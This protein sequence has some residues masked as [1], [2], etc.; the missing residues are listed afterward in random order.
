M[1]TRKDD[2][3]L[4]QWADIDSDDAAPDMSEELPASRESRRHAALD[5]EGLTEG[6]DGLWRKSVDNA[7]WIPQ[8]E[9]GYIT[10][11]VVRD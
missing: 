11:A 5:A 4:A 1:L 3:K 2:P 6:P 7:E 8:C 9:V 10:H